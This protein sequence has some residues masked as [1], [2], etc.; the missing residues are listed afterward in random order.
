MLLLFYYYYFFTRSFSMIVRRTAHLGCI[1][2]F[3]GKKKKFIIINYVVFGR[4]LLHVKIH[5]FSFATCKR[6]DYSI[7]SSTVTHVMFYNSRVNRRLILPMSS[8]RGDYKYGGV[9]F[10][11]IFRI[12]SKTKVLSEYS[13][14]G[15]YTVCTFFFR[16]VALH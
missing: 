14:Y 13:P 15:G 2:T 1:R 16:L 7:Y 6:F 5:S 10:L 3:R 12:V 9:F 4:D 8:N 11:Y